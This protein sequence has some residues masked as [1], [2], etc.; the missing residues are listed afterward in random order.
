MLVGQ[1]DFH[2]VLSEYVQSL[3]FIEFKQNVNTPPYLSVPCS[4]FEDAS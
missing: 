2:A 1:I 3:S 4:A